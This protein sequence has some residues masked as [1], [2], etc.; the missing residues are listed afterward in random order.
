[1]LLSETE[2]LVTTWEPITVRSTAVGPKHMASLQSVTF[3]ELPTAK[4]VATTHQ[5]KVWDRP[6][7]QLTEMRPEHLVE[8]LESR[9]NLGS[10]AGCLWHGVCTS[11]ASVSLPIKPGQ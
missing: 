11:E 10:F 2:P 7:P 5:G 6:G 1:M 3:P 9:F 4:T 8:E